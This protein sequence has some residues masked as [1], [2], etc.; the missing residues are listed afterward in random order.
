[1][2]LRLP[3]G[4]NDKYLRRFERRF[5]Y[6]RFHLALERLDERMLD[7]DHAGL[8]II[9]EALHNDPLGIKIHVFGLGVDKNTWFRRLLAND[10]D[11]HVTATLMRYM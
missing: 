4:K 3:P 5:L 7:K 1:M 9:E 10:A 2:T 8:W 11:V 6:R